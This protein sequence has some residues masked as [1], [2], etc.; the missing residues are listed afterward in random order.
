MDERGDR[1]AQIQQRVELDGATA[2]LV[3]RRGEQAQAQ[4]DGG[5]V[6]GIH[7]AL[8]IQAQILAAIQL[9]RPAD[10]D[11]GEVAINP[12]VAGFIGFGERAA[13]DGLSEA[14]VV[15]TFGSCIQTHLDVPQA[16]PYGELCK[17]KTEK[18]F[19]EGV[20][21]DPLISL[22]TVDATREKLTVDHLDDLGENEP[23]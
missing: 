21:P 17:S 13:G 6:Q 7:G 19:A 2:P 23:P 16:F 5:A 9:T 22:V 8:Q 11:L 3:S 18:L 4:F 1:T 10:Q 15:A 12:T 14:Q 20:V